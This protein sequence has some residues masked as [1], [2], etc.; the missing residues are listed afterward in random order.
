M[1][2]KY[3]SLLS[4]LLITGAQAMSPGKKVE[5]TKDALNDCRESLIKSKLPLFLK[6]CNKES[7]AYNNAINEYLL[8]F[9]EIITEGLNA[10]EE[11]RKELSFCDDLSFF[12]YL[13]S[14]CKKRAFNRHALA[15]VKGWGA[16]GIKR[17]LNKEKDI[18]MNYNDFQ[19]GSLYD[20]ISIEDFLNKFAIKKFISTDTSQQKELPYEMQYQVK[21]TD[22]I[23]LYNA[24]MNLKELIK[25]QS[26]Q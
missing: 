14:H 3:V 9:E 11:L 26:Q 25:K 1:N 17:T 24:K 19:Y 16:Y 8:P 4:V 21:G 12:E 18:Y 7:E 22:Q 2:I 10:S 13:S 20:K 23:T 5:H 6:N 15:V